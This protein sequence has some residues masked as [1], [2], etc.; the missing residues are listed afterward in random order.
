MFV[1]DLESVFV[2]SFQRTIGWEKP[3]ATYRPGDWTMR[4]GECPK[5][6]DNNRG[7]WMDWTVMLG[8]V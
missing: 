6:S 1:G 4:H 8:D 5:T 3:W 7:K 2:V